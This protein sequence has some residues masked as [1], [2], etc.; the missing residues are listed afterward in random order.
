MNLEKKASTELRP[1]FQWIDK[2]GGKHFISEMETRHL[3]FTVRMIW[4]HT[5]PMAARLLPYKQYRFS[6]IYG[7]KYLADAVKHMIP[8]LSERTDLQDLWAA[9]IER[10]KNW[11]MQQDLLKQP[12]KEIVN[13]SAV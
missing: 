8:E 10:M 3:F 1:P 2:D 5:M 4:N 7:P 6:A 12:Q 13:E 11:F 9:D